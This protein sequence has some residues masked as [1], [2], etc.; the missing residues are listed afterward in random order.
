VPS[1]FAAAI[2]WAEVPA[3]AGGVT[4]TAEAGADDSPDAAEG[5]EDCEQAT[6]PAAANNAQPASTDLRSV[7]DM[8]CPFA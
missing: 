3:G 2:A 7:E 4:P 1:T 6:N 8:E 5:D